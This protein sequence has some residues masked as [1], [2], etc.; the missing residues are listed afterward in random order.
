MKWQNFSLH[1]FNKPMHFQT[2][3]TPLLY[4]KTGF[5]RGTVYLSSSS[6]GIAGVIEW[7]VNFNMFYFS[8]LTAIKSALL[9]K[10]E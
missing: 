9:T 1:H 5:A 3:R 4:R 7:S 8:L 10:Y 2:L 6:E